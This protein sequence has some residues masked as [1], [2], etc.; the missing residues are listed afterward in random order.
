M[1]HI[2]KT[3]LILTLLLGDFD[4]PPTSAKELRICCMHHSHSG[5]EVRCATAW[6]LECIFPL[7]E[8]IKGKFYAIVHDWGD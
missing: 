3:L 2:M 5:H 7:C 6:Q 8:C 4:T 1:Q